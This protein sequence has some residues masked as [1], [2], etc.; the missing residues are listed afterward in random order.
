[1]AQV[2]SG[3]DEEKNRAMGEGYEIPGETVRQGQRNRT[4]AGRAGC[5]FRTMDFSRPRTDL[6]RWRG[7]TRTRIDTRLAVSVDT[8][9]L[10]RQTFEA[11]HYRL[12]QK[13]RLEG[14]LAVYQRTR[15]KRVLGGVWDR[16]VQEGM[17]RRAEAGWWDVKEERVKRE[18][19]DRWKL[20]A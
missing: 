13:E 19:W 14:Q 15:D 20:L 5:E 3:V 9:R 7:E 18:I 2:E 16:W 12:E 4:G 6:Q 10:L 17:I 11:W 1:M 8:D